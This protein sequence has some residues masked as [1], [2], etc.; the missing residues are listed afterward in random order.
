MSDNFWK[1]FFV[2]TLAGSTLMV[3][4]IHYHQSCFCSEDSC[5]C[6]CPFTSRFD[7]VKDTV[8]ELVDKAEEGLGEA[9]DKSKEVASN[10]KEKV[11][12]IFKEEKEESSH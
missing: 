9:V 6:I 5:S 7:R 2:G 8:E 10:A 11:E 4:W 1:G 12:D 3:G